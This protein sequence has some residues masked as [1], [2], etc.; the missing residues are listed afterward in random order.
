MIA[1]YASRTVQGLLPDIT[2]KTNPNINE[3]TIRGFLERYRKQRAE[4]KA[5]SVKQMKVIVGKRGRP[6]MMG[7]LD[8]QIQGF[9]LVLRS[10]GGVVNRTIA[11]AT[12]KALIES[13]SA[14]HLKRMKITESWAQ[15]LFR[16]MGF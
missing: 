1:Q 4:E 14:D 13:S 8:D 11:M 16:R 10:R 7:P 12:V 6:L 9:L 3:S 5:G 15:S 2:K